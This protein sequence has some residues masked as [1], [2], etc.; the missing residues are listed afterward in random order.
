MNEAEGLL[1]ST[2]LA[3]TV[4]AKSNQIK[5]NR[6]ESNRIESISVWGRGRM[7]R[8]DVHTHS[9]LLCTIKFVVSSRLV[10][11]QHHWSYYR[12]AVVVVVAAATMHACYCMLAPYPLLYLPF[13]YI[14]W[15]HCSPSRH[16]TT[17]VPN[18]DHDEMTSFL[19]VIT[20][21]CLT[22]LV[23]RMLVFVVVVVVVV[24]ADVAAFEV[25]FDAVVVVVAII[26]IVIVIVDEAAA[27]AAAVN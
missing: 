24:D 7:G 23:Q 14:T 19:H 4:C 18:L 27:A 11:S 6:I 2:R 16:M 21:T 1:D 5:S 15:L 26:V 8:L 20:R 12:T 22:V 13:I 9:S 10:S 25:G 17:T 3:I